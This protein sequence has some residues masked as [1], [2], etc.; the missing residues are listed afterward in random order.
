M[1]VIDANITEP[2]TVTVKDA[3]QIDEFHVAI[4]YIEGEDEMVGNYEALPEVIKTIL[5]VRAG[6]TVTADLSPKV[7]DSLDMHC[8]GAV[9]STKP[10]VTPAA[11][12]DGQAEAPQA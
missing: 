5:E 7:N 2:K 1:A 9:S 8:T 6:N 12:V 10:D 11:E 4:T 3:H